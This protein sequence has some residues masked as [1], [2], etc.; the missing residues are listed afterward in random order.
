MEPS[1]T[2]NEGAIGSGEGMGRESLLF[3]PGSELRRG[4]RE[5]KKSEDDT[6]EETKHESPTR[7]LRYH[8]LYHITLIDVVYPKVFQ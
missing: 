8:T 6:W 3:D 5:K 1:D 2:K 7:W 4:G